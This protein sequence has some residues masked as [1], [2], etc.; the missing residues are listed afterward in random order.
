MTAFTSHRAVL[1]VLFFAIVLVLPQLGLPPF[2]VTLLSYVGLYAIVA[3][4]LVLLTG[5][6]GLI[7]FGQ[8]AFVGIG[9][10]TTA[11]LT[12]QFGLSPWVGLLAG[13]GLTGLSAF[14]IGTLTMRISGHYL[15]LSTIAWACRCTT[16][17]ATWRCWA[18]MTASTAS[19]RLPSA[20]SPS[21]TGPRCIC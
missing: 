12:T 20:S 21:A 1:P 4:G 5:V 17:S 18:S 8:A 9:A 6:A 2:W 3:L 19:R 13:I 14:L 11:Y 10:Y 16:C 7:S 15:P